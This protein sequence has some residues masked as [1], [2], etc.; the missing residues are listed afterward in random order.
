MFNGK[1]RAIQ[2]KPSKWPLR[3]RSPIGDGSLRGLPPPSTLN[4][5]ERFA[6][7]PRGE[8]A[9]SRDPFPAGL[10]AVLGGVAGRGGDGMRSL[11]A[12]FGG[13]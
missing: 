12:P 9:G 2:L 6:R 1:R 10:T 11:A 3:I 7:A 5:A 4:V 13:C 8:T